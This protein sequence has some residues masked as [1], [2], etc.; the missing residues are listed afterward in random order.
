MFSAVIFS[1]SDSFSTD[2]F[3][4]E[5]GNE[6]KIGSAIESSEIFEG[7]KSGSAIESSEKSDSSGLLSESLS[8]EPDIISCLKDMSEKSFFITFTYHCFHNLF[9]DVDHHCWYQYS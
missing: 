6:L 3:S 5:A 1:F 9:V 2:S 4:S 8:V 7:L